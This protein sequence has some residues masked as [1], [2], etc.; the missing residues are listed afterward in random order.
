MRK[1]HLER[2]MAEEKE[3][4]EAEEKEQREAEEKEHREAEENA[5]RE[6]HEKE[7]EREA[8]FEDL[9]RQRKALHEERLA[10]Q[11]EKAMHEEQKKNDGK[12]RPKTAKTN[13]KAPKRPKPNPAKKSTEKSSTTQADTVFPVGSA[14][15][16]QIA[17]AKLRRLIKELESLSEDASQLIPLIY[18]R[19]PLPNRVVGSLEPDDLER[20]CMKAIKHYHPDKQG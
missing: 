10:F 18:R 13:A 11:K 14:T 2:I 6:A 8:F 12:K 3:Q 1:E 4:R 17:L 15:K 16:E 19:Y 9:E 5:Q 7:R 20:S